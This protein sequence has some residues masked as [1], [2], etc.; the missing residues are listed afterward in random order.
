MGV[1]TREGRG[2]WSESDDFARFLGDE[3]ACTRRNVRSGMSDKN[4]P[5]R[6]P[7]PEKKLYATHMLS[8][9]FDPLPCSAPAVVPSS[10]QINLFVTS[11]CIS[12]SKLL[13]ISR[14]CT[15]IFWSNA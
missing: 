2:G 15:H 9:P 12:L 13:A 5:E 4:R 3:I 7:C 1:T 10:L 6:G 11:F 14:V 8:Q